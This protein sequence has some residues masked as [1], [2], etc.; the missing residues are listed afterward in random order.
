[1]VVQQCY[2]EWGF[3]T[4]FNW[5]S[6]DLPPKTHDNSYTFPTEARKTLKVLHITDVHIDVDYQEGTDAV[7]NQPLCCREKS[8]GVE[9]SPKSFYWGTRYSCDIPFRTFEASLAA[10]KEVL[11]NPDLIFWTGDVPGV[12]S[13]L[14]TFS[15]KYSV[16][17]KQRMTFGSTH[18]QQ[19]K[20]LSRKLRTS[21][22]STFRAR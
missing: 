5:T 17:Q 7:C 15:P 22:S 1:M 21:L 16:S 12:A 8:R 18:S 20:D 2:P 3:F 11:P 10:A 6:V 4:T 13:N 19:P 14:T 9:N